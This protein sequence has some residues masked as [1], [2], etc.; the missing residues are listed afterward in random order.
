VTPLVNSATPNSPSA[1]INSF[2]AHRRIRVHLAI[3]N[4]LLAVAVEGVLKQHNFVLINDDNRCLI[5]TD[6]LQREGKRIIL[7]T[8]ESPAEAYAT[9]AAFLGNRVAGVASMRKP[10][11]I[12]M[13]IEAAREQ[14]AVLPQSLLAAAFHAPRLRDRQVRVLALMIEGL[15]NA[16]IGTRLGLSEAAVKR[17]VSSLLRAFDCTTRAELVRRA[18]NIGYSSR[19]LRDH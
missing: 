10:E 8:D 15:T 17:N 11:A 3:S 7:L 2:S 9:V 13:V 12:P 6:D 4:H 16:S 14:M 19:S 5:V 18:T 1:E